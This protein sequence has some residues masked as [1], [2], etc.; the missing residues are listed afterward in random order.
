LKAIMPS[1]P[2]NAP[3]PWSVCLSVTLV[4]PAKTAGQNEMPFGRN[5]RV[6]PSNTVLDRPQSPPQKARFMGHNPRSAAMPPITK[7]L[8][9]LLATKRK[10]LKFKASSIK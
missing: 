6:V 1:T 10:L 4:H 5:T 3:I 2:T 8:W 7:L 9:P